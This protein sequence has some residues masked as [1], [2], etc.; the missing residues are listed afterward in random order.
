MDGGSLSVSTNIG[1]IAFPKECVEK[2]AALLRARQEPLLRQMGT[3][4][5]DETLGFGR[6]LQE[7]LASGE[8][9]PV[10]IKLARY[11]RDGVSYSSSPSALGWGL[12]L[13][14][15]DGG[16]D[17][18]E[19]QVGGKYAPS[20]SVVAYSSVMRITVS[21]SAFQ[22]ATENSEAETLREVTQI[23]RGYA[24]P[25]A[26]E[27]APAPRRPFRV[28]L[29]HGGDEQWRIL[30][31]ELRDTHGFD[32]EAYE[33]IP[34][35]GHPISSILQTMADNSSA[36]LLIL[37]KTDAMA[38]NVMRGRQNVVHEIGFFQGRLG[39]QRAIVVVEDGVDLF[40]NLDGTQQIRF[41]ER[42]I[43][44]AVGEAVGALSML[45]AA[46]E[47]GF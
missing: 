12:D 1:T 17:E 33:G 41:P 27:P 47:R 46:H 37:T 3:E 21:E 39:W 9:P 35:A 31:D 5:S 10:S 29:G 43:R 6:D 45:K 42:N 18:V 26:P 14:E 40:S 16:Y 2:I 38:D 15:L 22:P 23:I 34:R 24:P 25:P 28:F 44:A 13:S 7:F 36:A 4:H 32:V 8:L 20:V 11:A 30:R 19:I